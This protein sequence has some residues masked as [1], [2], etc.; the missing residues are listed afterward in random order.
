[1]MELSI[2]RWGLHLRLAGLVIH[3]FIGDLYLRCPGIGELAWNSTG[4][5][6]NRLRKESPPSE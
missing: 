1:M 6:A 5:Y 2:G 4:L 3:A